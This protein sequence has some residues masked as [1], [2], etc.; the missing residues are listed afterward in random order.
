MRKVVIFQH[1]SNEILGTLNPLLKKRGLR[2]RY[3]NFERHPDEEPV[4]DRYNGIVIL[5][6][7]MGVY[8]ADRYTHIKVEMQLIEKALAKGIPI[9]GICL[10]SQILAHVLGAEVRKHSE[11]EI[12]WH[13]VHLTEEGQKDPL[14]SHFKKSEKIF[15]MHGD[16]FDIPKS[17]QHLAYSDLCPGQAFRYGDKVYGFQ[18]HLEVDRA[19]IDRWLQSP[20][21]Q[22]D[23][24]N[25]QGKFTAER[26]S[27]ETEQYLEHSIDLSQKTFSKFIDLF[28]LK[29]R[30][31]LLDSGHGKPRR[32]E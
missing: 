12:G 6:G 24:Q 16:T 27:S 1:V 9:L 7:H 13:D 2:I 10:G 28:Q 26:I 14:L 18:F 29:E 17:A 21:N 19:M 30:P 5:G 31:Q 20:M 8:E 3:V 11:K 22:E 4:L 23:L 15:Q 32:P 25:S